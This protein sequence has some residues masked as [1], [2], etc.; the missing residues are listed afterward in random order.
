MTWFG[1]LFSINHLAEVQLILKHFLTECSIIYMTKLPV[2][3]FP[4]I[5]TRVIIILKNIDILTHLI[6]VVNYQNRIHLLPKFLE[7]NNFSI[8]MLV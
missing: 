6:K 2:T 4:I 7:T 5:Y 1:E 8:S 3:K